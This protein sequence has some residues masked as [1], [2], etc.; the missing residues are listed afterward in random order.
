MIAYIINKL[1][2]YS[3][4]LESSFVSMVLFGEYP[5]PSIE[6]YPD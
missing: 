1:M 2:N 3:W 4:E 5:C 6:D